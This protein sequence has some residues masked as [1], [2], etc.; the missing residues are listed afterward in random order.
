[1]DSYLRSPI[2]FMLQFVSAAPI[3]ICPSVCSPKLPVALNIVLGISKLKFACKIT[4]RA[5]RY[6]CV[7]FLYCFNTRN[8]ESLFVFVIDS[9]TGN[10]CQLMN[11]VT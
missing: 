4:L 9:A 7:D 10:T 8:L 11:R 3:N 2:R 1:M 6:F 5:V